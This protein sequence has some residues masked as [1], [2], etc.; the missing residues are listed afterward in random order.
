[1]KEIF[2][3][4][5]T[6]YFKKKGIE[7]VKFDYYDSITLQ[8]NYHATYYVRIFIK[9]QN[10][11][12]FIIN[13]WTPFVV[14]IGK[15]SIF[16]WKTTVSNNFIEVYKKLLLIKNE[17]DKKIKKLEIYTEAKNKYTKELE[18][19]YKKHHKN[20]GVFIYNEQNKNIEVSILASDENLTTTYSIICNTDNKKYYL[21]SKFQN[22][23][24]EIIN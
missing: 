4:K 9:Q 2:V 12:K 19:Y 7:F 6:E 8:W 23:I 11:D 18:S 14:D 5:F 10:K 21:K 13:Y 20:V 22:N 16:K 17:L 15:K 1:M 24:N 3:N